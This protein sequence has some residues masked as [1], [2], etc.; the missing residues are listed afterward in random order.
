MCAKEGDQD[1]AWIYFVFLPRI[2]YGTYPN[3]DFR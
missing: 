3:T 1:K 2:L